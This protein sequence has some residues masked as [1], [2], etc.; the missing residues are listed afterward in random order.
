MT[1]S[2]RFKALVEQNVGCSVVFA[3]S[4]S[5]RPH[6]EK[7]CG[8]LKAFEIPHEVRIISAHKQPLLVVQ[9]IQDYDQLK[10]PLIYVAVAG[11]T[12]ALSGMLSY[13]SNRPTISCPPDG[14]NMSCLTN[15][16]GSSNVFVARPEN[17]GRYIAQS[18]SHMSSIYRGILNQQRSKKLDALTSA[19]GKLAL[20]LS[21][22][23]A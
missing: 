2:E 6:L 11:G 12:D 10:G 22:Y 3:G 9:A 5:D 7:I 1:V 19:D 18:Y 16:P 17:V 14:M 23:G 4:D 8:S 20:D 21:W 15:P 13:L